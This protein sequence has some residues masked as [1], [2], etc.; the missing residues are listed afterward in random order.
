MAPPTSTFATLRALQLVISDALD[1]I[2][3]VFA[4]PEIPSSPPSHCS[5]PVHPCF[6]DPSSDTSPFPATPPASFPPTPLSAT[7]PST[8]RSAPYTDAGGPFVDYPSPDLPLVSNSQAEQ[9]SLHPDAVAAASRIVAACGQMSNIVNKPF[10]SLCDAIMSYSLPACMRL[11]EHLHV[12]EILR[13]ANEDRQNG[14]ASPQEAA[15]PLSGVR[16][17][18]DAGPN[19]PIST[20][21]TR[22]AIEVRSP[23]PGVELTPGSPPHKITGMP[24]FYR[25]QHCGTELAMPLRGSSRHQFISS[26]EGLHIADITNVICSYAGFN[27]IDP[28]D[29]DTP[30]AAVHALRLLSTHHI[31]RETAPDT[32][33][34]N[35]VASLLDTG[36][37]VKAV[38][39]NPETKY[40]DTSGTP[41]FVSLITDEIFKSAAYLT[42]AFTGVQLPTLASASNSS[43][44]ADPHFS[45]ATTIPSTSSFVMNDPVTCV[46]ATRSSS[47]RTHIVYPENENVEPH[48]HSLP[49]TEPLENDVSYPLKDAPIPSH[50]LGTEPSTPPTPGRSHVEGLTQTEGERVRLGPVV[51]PEKLP[52]FN[53]AFRTQAPFFEWLENGGEDPLGGTGRGACIHTLTKTRNVQ[54]GDVRLAVPNDVFNCAP[55]KSFRLERFSKAMTGTTLWEAPK[56][57]LNGF[58][59]YSLPKGSTIVDVGG[60]IGSTTMVLAHALNDPKA[61]SAER[62]DRAH[63]E[64]LEPT[65]VAVPPHQPKLP[66]DPSL[67]A[68]AEPRNN[69]AAKNEVNIRFVV[70]DRP[71][72]TALGVEAWRSKFPEMIE[73]G[74]VVF[75]DH[76]F[77]EPQ[78]PF[79]PPHIARHPAVYILRVV[80]HDWPDE[81]ARRILI[82]LRVASNPE[83]R[84]VIAEHVLPLACADGDV[85]D[86]VNAEAYERTSAEEWTLKSVLANVEGAE[87]TLVPPPLLSNL[88]KA[89]AT[90]YWMDLIMHVTFN[91]KERTLREFCALALSAGWRVTRMTRPEGTLFAYLVCEP[92][93]LPDDAQAIHNAVVL[94]SELSTVVT[95]PSDEPVQYSC[96]EPSRHKRLPP[97]PA[98]LLPSPI[99]ERSSS[100]CG[101]PTFGSRILLPKD[102]DLPSLRTKG[103]GAARKWLKS[104]GLGVRSAIIQKAEKQREEQNPASG[105]SVRD[106]ND[107]QDAIRGSPSHM[108][109]WWKKSSP[110]SAS[111]SI[112]VHESSG[113]TSE[114][115]ATG[116]GWR[117]TF[118]SSDSSSTPSPRISPVHQKWPSTESA[119]LLATEA[120][121]PVPRLR[122]P[123]VASITRKLSFATFSRRPSFADITEPLP[124]PPHSATLM[125]LAPSPTLRGDTGRS[126]KR[127][128]SFPTLGR[129]EVITSAAAE[130]PPIP[131]R[132]SFSFASQAPLPHTAFTTA[133]VEHPQVS[134]KIAHEQTESPRPRTCSRVDVGPPPS[135]QGDAVQ[136]AR[137]VVEDPGT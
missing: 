14:L 4:L 7:F 31:F 44:P 32:F 5:S 65:S 49:S 121:P 132:P 130:R 101:T 87:R 57:I 107:V 11:V 125:D 50:P 83:T 6:P 134:C 135:A 114:H 46:P 127:L 75:Q 70:Q 91:A 80:L 85:L 95:V 38:F 78:L 84:L 15:V 40:D 116:R 37:S 35:R 72:V 47:I 10:S 104:K 42:E 12:A 108:R 53:L 67:M 8:L 90:A 17:D 58:D 1:D 110:T 56:A 62:R 71:I 98:S 64:E 51:K 82:N 96:L 102:E 27:Y 18:S 39:S 16:S 26:Q 29:L 118:K 100:R 33:A 19:G 97:R 28:N 89:S 131:R 60:G 136:L 48:S 74:Q 111:N 3:R 81:C 88:G 109:V 79:E 93:A 59:W 22:D 99:L 66:V 113:E 105:A 68:S 129:S 9:L 73:S 106:N 25:V 133:Q 120:S 41:A 77:F 24:P 94:S 30:L 69:T 23:M 63:N 122:R 115:R 21:L 124:T 103:A 34:L 52:A 126:L 61:D 86:H 92:I 2:Q 55:R 13:E 137:S 112:S 43:C 117:G 36:K 119:A 45:G 123:S 54:A 20:A 128:P 76:D